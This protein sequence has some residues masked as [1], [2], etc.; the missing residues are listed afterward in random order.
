MAHGRERETEF[1]EMLRNARSEP[2]G[3]ALEALCNIE[4]S[5]V[6][7]LLIDAAPDEVAGLQGEGRVARKFLK[8]L[9]ERPIPSLKS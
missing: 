6:K 8:Y 4:L 3:T 1:R 7:D 2:V 5:R 9:S